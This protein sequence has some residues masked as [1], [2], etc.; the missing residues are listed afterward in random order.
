LTHE[1]LE[2]ASLRQH[3]LKASWH[4]NSAAY[5]VALGDIAAARE[6][7]LEALRL[8]RQ[9]GHEVYLAVALQ[10]LALLAALGGDIQRGADL[11]GYVDARYDKL[12]AALRVTLTEDEITRLAAEG[13]AWSEDQAVEKARVPNCGP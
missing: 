9:V 11:L 12:M 10:H 6:S 3:R 2:L 5:C 7:A 1:A 4:N 13:G 8:A